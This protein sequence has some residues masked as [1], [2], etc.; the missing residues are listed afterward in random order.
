MLLEPHSPAAISNNA[1][2]TAHHFTIPL[3]D[4][5]MNYWAK[6]TF[7]YSTNGGSTSSVSKST[8]YINGTLVS[9]WTDNGKVMRWSD[10]TTL[11]L[12]E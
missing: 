10:S 3:A 4:Y 7:T 2:G 9:S 1:A 11:A 6:L 12:G 8:F 5:D